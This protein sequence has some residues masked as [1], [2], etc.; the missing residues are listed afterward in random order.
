MTEVWRVRVANAGVVWGLASQLL[1]VAIGA[2]FPLALAE[3]IPDAVVLVWCVVG[4]IYAGVM[5]IALAF[6][7]WSPPTG[8][9]HRPTRL[10]A[11]PVVQV[12]A[13]VSSLVAALIGISAAVMVVLLKDD[14]NDG[15]WYKIIG[16]WAMVLAWGVLHWG[17]AQWYHARYYR[18]L[19]PSMEFPGTPDPHLVDFAYFAYTVG[20]TFAASDVNVR[21][22][23]VRWVVTMHGVLAFFFNSA[24]IVLALSTLTG[25]N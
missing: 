20:T 15:L 4:T 14:P 16:V 10:Q 19:P 1:L 23:D 12:V 6:A 18:T 7:A 25:S 5:L 13:I 17:F 2:G 11:H 9:P 8:L 21:T 24:I 3:E 22:R